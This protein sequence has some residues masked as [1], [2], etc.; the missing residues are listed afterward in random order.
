[1]GTTNWYDKEFVEDCA[2]LI[3]LEFD[4]RREKFLVFAERSR[5][6]AIVLADDGTLVFRASQKAQFRPEWLIGI[7]AHLR[8]LNVST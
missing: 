5:L 3:R 1:M 8:W 7:G 4:E 2:K 6:G